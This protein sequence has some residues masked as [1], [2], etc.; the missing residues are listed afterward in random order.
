MSQATDRTPKD[1]S[2]VAAR[3]PAAGVFARHGQHASSMESIRYQLARCISNSRD[4][5]RAK[6]LLPSAEPRSTSKASTRDGLGYAAVTLD[7]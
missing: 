3:M 1:F 2:H 6:L 5:V 7:S 4:N